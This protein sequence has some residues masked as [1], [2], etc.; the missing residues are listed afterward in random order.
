M[1]AGDVNED[2]HPQGS[3]EA[4]SS[5]RKEMHVTRPWVLPMFRGGNFCE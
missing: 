4:G 3:E 1:E 2:L 5:D